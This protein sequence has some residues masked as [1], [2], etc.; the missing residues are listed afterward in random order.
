MSPFERDAA[1]PRAFDS[2]I[3]MTPDLVLE[4]KPD[5]EMP[6]LTESAIAIS[7]ESTTSQCRHFNARQFCCLA[8]AS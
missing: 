3:Q 1:S 4:D 6:R 2:T 5:P 8:F 7:G